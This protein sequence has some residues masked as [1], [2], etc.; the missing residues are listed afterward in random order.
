MANKRHS[1]LGRGLDALIPQDDKA[2]RRAEAAAKAGVSPISTDE[3]AENATENKRTGGGLAA[4][5]ADASSAEGATLVRLSRVEPNRSQPRKNFDEEALEELADSIKKYGVLQPILVQDRDSHYEIIAGERRW[6]AAQKAGLKEVPVIIRKYTEQEIL[7]LSLIENIQREDLN[8]I[9]EA[10]AY[11]QLIKEFGLKQEEIAE[12]VSKSRSAITN[13]MRLLKLDERV[14]KMVEQNELSMGHARALIPVEDPEKQYLLAQR[15]T[16]DKLSVRETEK[17]IKNL[18]SLDKKAEK[19]DSS[20]EKS[21]EQKSIELFL[22]DME[23]TAKESI[24]TK[25]S[26]KP[27]GKKGGKVEIEYYN[28]D[29]LEKIIERITHRD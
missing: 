14:Q 1:G 10:K 5:L 17:L 6:R 29:D 25:V 11:Q 24:G 3:N 4:L 9:E 18:D 23:R 15:I 7:E 26:I 21:E 19:S 28:N 16:E 22:R 8:P 20:R 27:K 2:K 13:A 12:R